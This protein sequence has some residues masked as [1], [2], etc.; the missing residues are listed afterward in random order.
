MIRSSNANRYRGEAAE[1]TG[2]W[3]R[4]AALSYTSHESL[5][6]DFPNPNLG[7]KPTIP[8]GMSTTGEVSLTFGMMNLATGQLA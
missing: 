8:V 3:R 6:R 7:V 1:T 4:L 2:R 5:A